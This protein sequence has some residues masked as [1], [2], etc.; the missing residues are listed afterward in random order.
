MQARD[1]GFIQERT[2]LCEGVSPSRSTPGDGRLIYHCLAI[3][4]PQPVRICLSA[5]QI[6]S[7]SPIIVLNLVHHDIRP[8]VLDFEPHHLSTLVPC[9]LSASYYTIILTRTIH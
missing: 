7:F 8:S 4:L 6:V 5:F 2:A 1:V 9:S 3:R